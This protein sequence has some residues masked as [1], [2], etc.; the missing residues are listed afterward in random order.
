M[1][2]IIVACRHPS[3]VNFPL[4]DG[5][6]L[7]LAGAYTH[8]SFDPKIG[9]LLPGAVG[10]TEVEDSVWDKVKEDYAD[11]PL[12]TTGAVFAQDTAG[13]AKAQ[14]KADAPDKNE[15]AG[16]DPQKPG[17]KLEPLSK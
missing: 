10:L 12:L 4:P 7:T 2:K 3:G 11:H 16:I 17:G 14:A 5:R 6:T 9:R 13:K 8:N 1:A 15:M